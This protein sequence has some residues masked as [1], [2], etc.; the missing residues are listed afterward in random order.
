MAQSIAET[1]IARRNFVKGAALASAASVAAGSVLASSQALASEAPAAEI[2]WDGEYD[3]VV[4]GLGFSG[5][6]AATTAADEGAKVLIV[7]KCKDGPAGG[8]SRVCAQLILYGNGDVEA[9][10]AYLASL[11]DSREVPDDVLDVYAEAVATSMDV[12]RDTFG[13]PGEE[14]IDV[15]DMGYECMSPEYPEFEG[16]DKL[17]LYA[18]HEGAFDSYLYQCM[19]TR[20]EEQYADS[21]EVWFESP[22]TKLIQDPQDGTIIGV[23]VTQGDKVLNIK[24]ANGVV[25]CTGGFEGNPDM[26]QQYLDLGDYIACGSTDNTGDGQRMCQEV[27]ADLWHMHAWCGLGGLGGISLIVPEGTPAQRINDFNVGAMNSGACIL[28]GS[29]GKRYVNESEITRHG[30]VHNGN[31]QWLNPEFPNGIHLIYD[32]AQMDAITEAGELPEGFA[33]QIITCA[34]IDEAAAAI[35]CEA[36]TLQETI[37]DF[38]SFAEGG[39]DYEWG[40]AADTMRAFE[41]DTY[42]LLPVKP[43]LLNTQGGPRRGADGAVIDLYGNPIPHLYSAGECG[44]VT[45]FMY[46]GGLN[47]C[48][49]FMMGQIAGKS[50]ASAK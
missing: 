24:A 7:E 27:G 29:H 23:E 36:A 42:Y 13:M 4:M 50:A 5:M 14:F 35:G 16:S 33:D 6:S 32:Q 11:C 26:V 34:S 30:K 9:S 20:L 37:D 18:T 49:C 21:V 28:V 40:R 15:A 3:V 22:A 41:G 45:S 10:R 47:V 31:G 48:E 44:G 38:N 8:N 12:I 19:R 2:A 39:K 43:A 46:P 17:R 1:S 25:V